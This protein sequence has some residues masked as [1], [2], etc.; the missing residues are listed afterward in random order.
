MFRASTCIDRDIVESEVAGCGNRIF[1]ECCDFACPECQCRWDEM[2]E[3][4]KQNM[5]TELVQL[6]RLDEDA[7]TPGQGRNLINKF[8]V[9]TFCGSLGKGI[10]KELPDCCLKGVCSLLK[11]KDHKEEYTGFQPVSKKFK[12]SSN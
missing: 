3:L 5:E 11:N 8:I 1:C 4:V 10:W 6:L 2:E 9:K 12:H 7:I